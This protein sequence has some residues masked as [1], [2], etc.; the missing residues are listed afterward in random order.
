MELDASMAQQTYELRQERELLIEQNEL[1]R[2]ILN[3]PV[4]QDRDIFNA[5]RRET[6]KFGRRTRKD[7]YPIY[8]RA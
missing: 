7:P 3:K 1:L 4:I 5:N 8:G 6:L 2:A